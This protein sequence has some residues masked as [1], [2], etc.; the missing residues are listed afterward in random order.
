MHEKPVAVLQQQATIEENAPFMDQDTPTQDNNRLTVT[1]SVTEPEDENDDHTLHHNHK[2]LE[3]D[4][5]GNVKIADENG[6]DSEINSKKEN[7]ATAP[8]QTD[9]ICS[10]NEVGVILTTLYKVLVHI[11]DSCVSS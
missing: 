7:K 4:F 11:I 3:M 6:I 5:E 1:V 8:E 2:N 10:D 9:I